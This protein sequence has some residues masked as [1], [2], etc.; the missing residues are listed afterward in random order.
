MLPIQL[1]LNSN[2]PLSSGGKPFINR[3]RS[4]NTSYGA[5]DTIR[6][7][8]PCGRNG[9]FLFPTDSFLEAKLKVNCSNLSTTGSCFI[10]GTVYS[11]FH[12]MRILHGST[13][14]EDTLHC[15]RLWNVLYDVQISDTDRKQDCITKLINDNTPTGQSHIFNALLQA[16]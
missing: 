14:L 13:V 4:D 9:Q 11:L 6:I 8:I 3:Y 1:N 10:D 2:K 16:T 12:R 7:E 5:G 15:N